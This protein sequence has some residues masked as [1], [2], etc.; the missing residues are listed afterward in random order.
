MA[1]TGKDFENQKSTS[2]R[3]NSVSIKQLG[4]HILTKPH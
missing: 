3:D 4:P 2:S 1:D